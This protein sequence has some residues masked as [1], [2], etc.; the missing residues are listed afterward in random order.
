MTSFVEN[1]RKLYPMN[2]RMVVVVGV[3]N[4]WPKTVSEEMA[5]KPEKNKEVLNGKVKGRKSAIFD[6]KA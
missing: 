6:K 3:K 4:H 1:A 2:V 5:R